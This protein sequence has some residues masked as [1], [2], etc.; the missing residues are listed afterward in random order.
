MPQ[1]TGEKKAVSTSASNTLEPCR[2][3]SP[4]QTLDPLLKLK[5]AEFACFLDEIED[6]TQ[7]LRVDQLEEV[8]ADAIATCGFSTPGEARSTL[9]WMFDR[10]SDLS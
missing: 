7:T 2:G 5:L 1:F 8:I 3:A 4:R 10:P 9:E 6:C